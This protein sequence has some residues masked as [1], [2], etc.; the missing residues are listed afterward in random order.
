MF[1]VIDTYLKECRL[2]WGMC[3]SICTDGA[4]SMTEK[5]KVLV[6][7]VKNQNPNMQIT[8]CMLHREALIT[9]AM[10]TDLTVTLEQAVKIVNYIKSRP[11][12]SRLFT[13]L[14]NE[15]GSEQRLHTSQTFLV[16]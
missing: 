6:T 12:K 7:M 8:H 14:C 11:L 4:A 5:V 9:K 13:I 16:T 1:I 10:P 15:M 3:H 2:N